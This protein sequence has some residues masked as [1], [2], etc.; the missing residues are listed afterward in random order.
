MRMRSGIKLI[1]A[2]NACACAAGGNDHRAAGRR[3]GSGTFV[4]SHRKLGL[5]ITE[6]GSGSV[7]KHR[8]SVLFAR[9]WRVRST[10]T[11]SHSLY[12]DCF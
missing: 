2:H 7:R 10:G 5:V 11:G 6:R 3:D 8:P 1:L 12:T 4:T 9:A